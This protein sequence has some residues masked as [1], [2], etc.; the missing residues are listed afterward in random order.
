MGDGWG[1]N[2]TARLIPWL[3]P[4]L[5]L[6][7]LQVVA[8]TTVQSTSDAK[9]VDRWFPRTVGTTWLYSSRTNG[10][11]TG[12]HVNQV[13]ST[14]A[15]SDG[16]ATVIQ[17]RWTD[18]LGAGPSTQIV[19]QGA[20]DDR[21]VLHGQRASGSYIPYEP[22]QPQWDR[23]LA[24]GGSF[25]WAGKFGTEEQ[26]I[27]TTLEAEETVVVAGERHEAGRTGQRLLRRRDVA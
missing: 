24:P 2:R 23:S 22:P 25:T 16:A 12:T 4:A 13:V 19:Y 9:E 26:R 3:L 8:V 6:G 17:G 1:R 14:G 20:G 7:A 10:E 11:D 5:I 27:T 21:L 15:T 18:L